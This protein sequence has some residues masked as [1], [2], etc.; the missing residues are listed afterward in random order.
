MS[1]DI[2]DTALLRRVDE[3]RDVFRLVDAKY[4]AEHPTAAQFDF[5]PARIAAEERARHQA[6]SRSRTHEVTL[7]DIYDALRLPAGWTGDVLRETELAIERAL[8]VRNP[9]VYGL[10]R[11]AVDRGIPVVFL[12]DMYMPSSFLASV[13]DDAGYTERALLLVSAEADGASKA[14]GGLY[15][16]AVA[17]LGVRPDEILH[18]GDNEE[19]DVRSALR[20]GLTAWHYCRCAEL[21][22]RSGTVHP[23]RSVA[24]MVARGLIHNQLWADRDHERSTAYAKGF[25]S[26]GLLWHHYEGQEAAVRRAL[27]LWPGLVGV[28]WCEALEQDDASELLAGAADFHAQLA[29]L[30][31]KL[32]WLVVPPVDAALA[33]DDPRAAVLNDT[34]AVEDPALHDEVSLWTRRSLEYLM[35]WA[36]H[37]RA[38]QAESLATEPDDALHAL[39]VDLAT[40][41]SRFAP[42]A[43]L[44]ARAFDWTLRRAG[45][46]AHASFGIFDLRDKLLG[47]LRAKR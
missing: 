31:A 35:G 4:R 24:S 8:L 3:P 21:A 29:E 7:S 16:A 12:S 25:T 44:R 42:P 22:T 26:L 2:F 32:P 43:S 46:L 17:H 34:R 23:G 27:R 38:T 47:Q 6:Y 36:Q 18:I 39:I 37:E 1:L 33:L 30:R 5:V 10:Y 20:R 28:R 14:T 19:S 15:R 45:D 9:Y 11:A 40:F 13:L 41:R